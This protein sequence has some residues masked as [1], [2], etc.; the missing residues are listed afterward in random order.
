ME[1]TLGQ[2]NRDPFRKML[3]GVKQYYTAIKNASGARM[4]TESLL[5]F[6][7]LPNQ[8]MINNLIRK[9]QYLQQELQKRS[10]LEQWMAISDMCVC[11]N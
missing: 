5:M 8:K 1:N 7:I 6:I 2:K 3:L 10:M 9:L 4:F 11:C